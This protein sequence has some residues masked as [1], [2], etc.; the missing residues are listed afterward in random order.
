[1]P[2]ITE[3]QIND[4]KNLYALRGLAEADLARIAAVSEIVEL[5]QDQRLTVQGGEEAPFYMV[6]AGRVALE[7]LRGVNRVIPDPLPY[8]AG[9]F[10]GADALLF[11]R[12]RRWIATAV[13]PAKLLCIASSDLKALLLNIPDFKAGLLFA[14]QMQRWLRDK[15]FRWI[16]DDEQVYLISRKHPVFLLVMLMLPV[17]VLLASFLFF[18]LSVS[19]T[20]ASFKWA[21]LWIGFVVLALG[22]AW[23]VWRYIDWGNDFYV[24]TDLRVVWVEQVLFM[25]ESRR[26]AFL[27]SIR[28]KQISTA[29]W[30]ERRFGFGDIIMTVYAG[31]L[32]F[33]NIPEPENAAHLIDIL[34]ARSGMRLKKTDVQQTQSLILKKI[35][36]VEQIMQE[37]VEPI[38]PPAPPKPKPR[39]PMLPTWQEIRAFFQT[40]TRFELGEAITYR[41]HLIFLETKLFLPILAL[42]IILGLAGFGIWAVLNGLSTFPSIPTIIL[43]ALVLSVVFLAWALYAFVD[44]RNDIYQILPDKLVDK[45][46]KPFQAETVIQALLKDIN[47]MEIER[48]NALGILMNFGTVVIN[49]GTDQ[50][51]TF[52]NIPDPARALQ[53]IYNYLY[54]LQRSQQVADMLKQAEQSAVT[55]AAY[56]VYQ[57]SQRG[58]PPNPESQ[59]PAS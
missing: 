41:T 24:I 39:K 50:K 5:A 45:N 59:S 40:E 29:N 11:S 1:M 17:L 9:L 47:S 52:N 53:D 23:A 25:Y 56:K 21:A 51:L 36:E 7:E 19:L 18:G 20:T 27:T 30:L 10:F 43:T 46:H 32:V 31:Q 26:E 55:L 38:P 37:E 14:I 13:R 8:K 6:I 12:A 34:V 44:W 57:D 15:S 3:S 2:G 33:K 16:E 54:K 22:L 49:S 58:Q 42:V 28:N 35:R 4:L 48:P